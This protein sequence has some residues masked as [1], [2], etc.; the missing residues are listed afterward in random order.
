M[1]SI[2]FLVMSFAVLLLLPRVGGEYLHTLSIYPQRALL[3]LWTFKQ[4]VGRSRWLTVY[5]TRRYS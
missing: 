1:L 5:C 4:I 3:W 2:C